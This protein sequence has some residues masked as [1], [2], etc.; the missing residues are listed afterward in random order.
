MMDW[1]V[2]NLH[3]IE[4]NSDAAYCEKQQCLALS[5]RSL[6]VND[7]R[8]W[9]LKGES[10]ER[11]RAALEKAMLRDRTLSRKHKPDKYDDFDGYD[12]YENRD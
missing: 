9:S 8:P 11:L 1:L 12:G 4:V 5:F 2:D 10:R 6:V 3:K 7:C